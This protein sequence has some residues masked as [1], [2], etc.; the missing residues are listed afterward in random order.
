M[1]A[2]LSATKALFESRENDRPMQTLAQL[3]ITFV[4]PA[5]LL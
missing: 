3:R 2:M 4:I 5:A 1:A